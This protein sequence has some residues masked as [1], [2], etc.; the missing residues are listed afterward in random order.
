M[1]AREEVREYYR[2]SERYMHDDIEDLIINKQ[3]AVVW[4]KNCCILAR[5]V[6]TNDPVDEWSYRLWEVVDNP[7]AWYVHVM[8]GDIKTA[9][10]LAKKAQPLPY[11]VFQRGLRND[12]VHKIPMDKLLKNSHKMEL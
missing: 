2:E 7:D 10:E 1:D 9:M 8:A 4:T 5:M 12:K 6:N 3:G 11:V